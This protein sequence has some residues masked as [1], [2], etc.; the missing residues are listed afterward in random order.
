MSALLA[1][2][3]LLAAASGPSAA[4]NE[5]ERRDGYIGATDEGIQMKGGEDEDTVIRV[6]PPEGPDEPEHPMPPVIVEPKVDWPPKKQG[7][8]P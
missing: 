2:C 3:L 4:D 8:N 1:A 7:G 5:T 6:R